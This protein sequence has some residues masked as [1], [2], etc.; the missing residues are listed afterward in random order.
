MGTMMTKKGKLMRDKYYADLANLSSET[1]EYVRGIPVV[2]TF[3]QSIESFDR[4]Y[5]LIVKMKDS[6]M[7]LTMSYRN[8]MAV[9]EAITG[10]T[11]FFL[12]PVA[13]LILATGG[14]VREVLDN[15]VI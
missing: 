2:K 7:E 10:S 3:A 11:A 1:V 6:V 4:L 5:S 9:F 8:K 15:S 14:N 13:L 12:V